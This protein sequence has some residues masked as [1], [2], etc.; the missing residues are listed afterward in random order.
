ML[1]VGASAKEYLALS[2]CFSVCG[3]RS[4][5]YQYL[6]HLCPI[7]IHSQMEP[8]PHP[9]YNGEPADWGVH[10]GMGECIFLYLYNCTFPHGKCI[11]PCRKPNRFVGGMPPKAHSPKA[12]SPTDIPP[13]IC[14]LQRWPRRSA[15]R[16]GSMEDNLPAS[17]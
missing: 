2:V 16:N 3:P 7:H 5:S 15:F 9:P 11:P 12:Y 17:L 1:L 6:A 14:G 13:E 10:V 4:V 8:L